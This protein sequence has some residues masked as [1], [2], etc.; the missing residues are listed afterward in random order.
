MEEWR[1]K[2]LEHEN[3]AKRLELQVSL[4]KDEMQKCKVQ[5]VKEDKE[6][7]APLS[8]GKQLANEKRFHLRR[9]LEED[10]RRIPFKDIGNS[11]SLPTQNPTPTPA[12]HI[13][14]VLVI[15]LESTRIS[16]LKMLLSHSFM[17]TPL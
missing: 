2:A 4:L 15:T 9:L 6:L 5:G 11:S 7:G 16:D 14:K 10:G 12:P 1:E 13:Y 17:L 3:K 8:L